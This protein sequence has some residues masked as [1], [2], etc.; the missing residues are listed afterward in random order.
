[1]I[2]QVLRGCVLGLALISYLSGCSGSGGPGQGAAGAGSSP[3]PP[4]QQTPDLFAPTPG[5]GVQSPGNFVPSGNRQYRG[6]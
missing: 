4:P 1:M 2:Q 3:P 5:D 6:N